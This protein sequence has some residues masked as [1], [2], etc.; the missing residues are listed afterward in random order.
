[1][2]QKEPFYQTPN[3]DLSA[4]LLSEGFPVIEIQYEPRSNGNKERG[5]FVFDRTENLMGKVN[6]YETG[7]A[8]INL[9]L[10]QHAKAR[11]F[12]R[13]MGRLP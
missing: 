1:M 2:I 6:L 7:K 11:L 4:Y 13:L 10:F 8:T 9:A 3:T 5:I 12:D